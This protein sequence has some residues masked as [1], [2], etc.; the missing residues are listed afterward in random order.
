MIEKR[1]RLKLCVVILLGF[2]LSWAGLLIAQEQQMIESLEFREVDIKDVLRQLAKQYNL[3]IIFSET[4]KGLVTVQLNNV[5]IEQALDSIITV[6]GFA[7]SK[8]DNVYKVTTQDEVV[9]QG[10]QTKL[11]KLNNAD[12]A[13]LKVTLAKVLSSDGSIE[14]DSRSNSIIVTDSS[15]V[16]NKIE[17]MV[18]SLDELT[19][20]VL[21][22]AKMIETSLTVNDKLGIDWTT[23]IKAT[24]AKRA[25][26]FPFSPKGGNEFAQN[27]LPQASSTDAD[28][29]AA[30]PTG[31][32]YTVLGDFTFGTLDFSSFQ[33]ILDFLKSRNKTKLVANPRIVTINNQNAV[34]NV[35]KVLSLP[36]YER[37]ETTGN[38]EITG[39]TNYNVGV[40]LDVTPQV[41]PDGHIKLKL[42]PEVSSLVGYASERDGVKEGPITSSRSAQTEVQIK[43]GQTVVIGGMVKD[44]TATTEK[45]IPLL[46]DIP[47]LGALFRRKEVGSTENPTEKTDLLIF[48]TAHIIKDDDLPLIASESN[49]V[50]ALPRPAKLEMREIK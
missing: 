17:A 47:F 49:M 3:N 37:N 45:K 4:V 1:V 2:F 27:F 21:I 28:F 44:E 13:T 15:S 46:G 5:S 16:I 36:T 35:G 19:S 32:P 8:K 20:Q 29:N 31:F 12:A 48:V 43:D 6:N 33:T 7:Y 39:W 23:T 30:N 50:T 38:L 14:S 42:K 24:G 41:S 26:T 9:K 40:K 34:I 22:E 11:F 18:P 10:N 25:I